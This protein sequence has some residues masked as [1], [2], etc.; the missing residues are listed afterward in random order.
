MNRTNSPEYPA[1]HAVFSVTA[2]APRF[3]ITHEVPAQAL[4]ILVSHQRVAIKDGDNPQIYLQ[5][6]PGRTSALCA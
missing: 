3:P 5:A 1:H 2:L 6:V 4:W